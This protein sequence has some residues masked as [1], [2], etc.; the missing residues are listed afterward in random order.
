MPAKKVV[1]IDVFLLRR[2]RF[3]AYVRCMEH[4]IN[5]PLKWQCPPNRQ[6]SIGPPR[7]SADAN[8]GQKPVT[9]GSFEESEWSGC[10]NIANG[11]AFVS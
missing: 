9:V 1:I 10:R 4:A 11:I 3:A 7:K 5:N 8:Q 6:A 2:G